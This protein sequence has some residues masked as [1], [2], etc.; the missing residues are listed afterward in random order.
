MLSRLARHHAIFVSTLLLALFWSFAAQATWA[1]IVLD[2]LG[3]D[4]HLADQ[5]EVLAARD[6]VSNVQPPVTGY[7]HADQ[8]EVL[9]ARDASVVLDPLNAAVAEE[10]GGADHRWRPGFLD[11]D[12]PDEHGREL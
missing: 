8:T 6:A 5:A 3:E 2:D 12:D 11:Y 10:G 4:Y 1:P 7:F 9:A